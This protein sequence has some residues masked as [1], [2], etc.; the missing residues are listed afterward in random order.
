MIAT[1]VA[2]T[3]SVINCEIPAGESPRVF[4]LLFGDEQAG[5]WGYWLGEGDI[6]HWANGERFVR[7]I[8]H[9]SFPREKA[10]EAVKI[11]DELCSMRPE[12]DITTLHAKLQALE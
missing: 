12:P 4:Y 10:S 7:V 9:G 8:D 5:G 2:W 6:R 11:L 3:A 1:I